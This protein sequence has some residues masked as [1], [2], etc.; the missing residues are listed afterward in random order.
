M[1]DPSWS[2]PLPHLKPGPKGSIDRSS[3]VASLMGASRR[4]ILGGASSLGGAGPARSVFDVLPGILAED[5]FPGAARRTNP[6]VAGGRSL[7]NIRMGSS[8]LR[9]AREEIEV[10]QAEIAFLKAGVTASSM[11]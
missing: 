11:D 2:Q 5:G 3:A 4:R 10:L 7:N 9:E 1:P 6:N 8:Q